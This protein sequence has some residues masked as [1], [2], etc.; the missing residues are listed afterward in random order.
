[1]GRPIVGEVVVLPLPQTNLQ[2][3]KRLWLFRA[4]AGCRFFPRRLSQDSFIRP[5]KLFALEQSGFLY[6]AGTIKPARLEQVKT[7]I[8][9]LFS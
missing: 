2:T 6:V 8:R 9:K 4:A 1:M 3:G 5:Q 7:N